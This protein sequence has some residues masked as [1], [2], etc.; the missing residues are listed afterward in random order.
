MFRSKGGTLKYL[1]GKLI[2]A[3][4]P[5]L[6][7]INCSGLLG[8]TPHRETDDVFDKFKQKAIIVRSSSDQEDQEGKSGAGEFLSVRLQANWKKSQL[9]T[10]LFQILDCYEQKLGKERVQNQEIIIQV[11][12]QDVAFSGVVFTRELNL[13]APYIV[14]NYDDVTGSTSSVTS[15]SGAYSNKNLFIHRNHAEALRSDRFIRLALVIKELE[16]ICKNTELD[17]EF[18]V[19]NDAKVH[20]LQV[21]PITTNKSW[22]NNLDA[23]ID[24]ELI[25]ISEVLKS[26]LCASKTLDGETTLFG[27]M[28]DWN[29]AEIIGKAPRTLASSLYQKL[30]TDGVWAE[31]RH[32]M[33]Y[34]APLNTPLMILLGGQ[35]YIDVRASLNSFIPKN[36]APETSKKL[37]NFW[38][39]SLKENPELH[40]KIEFDVA[41]TSYRFDISEK[42]SKLEL[43]GLLT[44][45]ECTQFE[46]KHRE[47]TLALIKGQSNGAMDAA[48]QKVSILKE[49]QKTFDSEMGIEELRSI[50]HDC[51][52]FGTKPFAILARH[53]FIAK[54]LLF[55]LT[56]VGV[57]DSK[58]VNNF[59][60]S[61]E[62]VASELVS[63]MK[64]V[65]DG[66][67]T[68]DAFMEQYGHLRPGTYDISSLKYRD[69]EN[70]FSSVEEKPT[71]QMLKRSQVTF[72]LPKKTQDKIDEL[73]ERHCFYDINSDV[74]FQYCAK[75]IAQREY[76]KFVF[77]RSISKALDLIT[78]LG[79]V[80][81]L[82]A[83]ELA[84]ID[85]TTILNVQTESVPGGLKGLLNKIVSFNV[86]RHEVTM[87]L[88]LPQLIHDLEGIFIIP[89][90]L[91][92][93]NFITH[94]IAAGRT[95]WLSNASEV[96][97][98][99]KKIV[100]IDNADPGY[101]WIFS[102][103]ISALITK[104]GGINSHMAIRCAEFGIPAAIGCGDEFFERIK[105]LK[106]IKIDCSARLISEVL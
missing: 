7:L 22:P 51:M 18:A 60:S 64:N 41:I 23:R 81:G 76:S 30:I 56:A 89:H 46:Q 24:S 61:V 98:L 43:G 17:I 101:D 37:I 25:G 36:V 1:H 27:Q 3:S 104:F 87:A 19:D 105:S 93:P 44:K 6:I 31:A 32:E 92:E 70:F 103:N 85:I 50:L 106:K 73:L 39:N 9:K 49:R 15:G 69:I 96:E 59:L 42:L 82:N 10:A 55:S 11:M 40:D 100:F 2:N 34:N 47:M 90:Q 57:L 91:S 77:S 52:K 78:K 14:V 48:I 71:E 5:D 99:D 33:G 95:K 38:L 58:D 79:K 45:D 102:H 67:L 16:I 83:L 12:V 84:N 35:P 80:H 88:K 68:A 97:N 66:I 54:N 63:D 53:A 4:V 8:K 20:I 86:A 62:T 74:F 94:K 29:P 72:S 65:T 28:P 21:R 13:G 75:A 26:K